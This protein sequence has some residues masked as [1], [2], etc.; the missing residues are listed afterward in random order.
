M[1]EAE[2]REL[3]EAWVRGDRDDMNFVVERGEIVEGRTF[4]AEAMEGMLDGLGLFV[5]ARIMA[6][7]KRT[8]EPPSRVSVQVVV[9]AS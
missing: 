5:G 4:S 7:W 6:R 1:N 8:G 9:E 2:R 3:Y